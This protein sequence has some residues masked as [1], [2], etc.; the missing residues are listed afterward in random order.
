MRRKWLHSAA[1]IALAAAMGVSSLS[2]AFTVYAAGSENPV[3]SSEEL[4][5][6]E[7]S[8]S[9]QEA[10]ETSS[11]ASTE[12]TQNEETTAVQEETTQQTSDETQE[13]SSEEQQSTEALSESVPAETETSAE[14]EIISAQAAT[15]PG[16]SP[17][18]VT[19]IVPVAGP[20]GS[21]L[22]YTEVY[23]NSDATI[24]MGEYTFYYQ[25]PN[26][27]GQ[28]WNT[29]DFN[30][31]PGECIVLWQSNSSS[32]TVEDFNAYYG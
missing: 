31:E 17:L 14:N 19:E 15:Q 21:R 16:A 18:I 20:S 10:E 12:E 1:A 24:N 29:G 11:A 4:T 27:G 2:G 23:N 32:W 3:L 22:T 13:S 30:I 8:T 7:E 5:S 6:A 25:Y 26:G 9:A 28:V